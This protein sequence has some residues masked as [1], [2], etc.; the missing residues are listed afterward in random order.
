[1][2][3]EITTMARINKNAST[4][5]IL[6]IAA[7]QQKPCIKVEMQNIVFPKWSDIGLLGLMFRQCI[8]T[9]EQ[10]D[11]HIYDEAEFQP[12]MRILDG[13]VL[14]SG[15]T[16]SYAWKFSKLQSASDVRPIGANTA[17]AILTMCDV[18]SGISDAHEKSM[19]ADMFAN[20]NKDLMLVTTPAEDRVCIEVTKELYEAGVTSCVDE[21]NKV[22][23]NGDAEETFLNIGDFLIVGANGVYCIRRDEFMTTHKFA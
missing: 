19:V 10:P 21:W 5:N 4:Q 20:L 3:R 13:K 1:M 6:N 15:K 22:D 2:K 7:S 14:M 9:K 12:V 16:D 23:A 18:L 8:I 11:G 17:A